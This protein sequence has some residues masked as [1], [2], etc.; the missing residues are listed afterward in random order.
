[1]MRRHSRRQAGRQGDEDLP[2]DHGVVLVVGIIGVAEFAVGAELKLQEL[3]PKVALVPHV[4]PQVEH[5]L[6]TTGRDAAISI[7]D[8]GPPPVSLSPLPLFGR[9][10]RYISLF[11][12][13]THRCVWVMDVTVM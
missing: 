13:G 9:K 8:S 2:A 6:L 3:V 11:I 1:M 10:R 4:V 7:A 5:I 12:G